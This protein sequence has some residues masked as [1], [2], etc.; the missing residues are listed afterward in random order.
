MPGATA[1]DFD[2]LTTELGEGLAVREMAVEMDFQALNGSGSGRV[3]EVKGGRRV[4][5]VAGA[6]FL[7]R[8]P[9]LWKKLTALGGNASLRRHGMK[10]GKGEPA[11][12]TYHSVTVPPAVFEELTVIDPM[13][14][15]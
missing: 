14:K 11:Q 1:L 5:R 4:A 10:A 8:A 2:G 6:E 7:F 12:E 9:E 15:A 13:R 3:Y